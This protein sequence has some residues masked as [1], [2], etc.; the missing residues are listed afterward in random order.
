MSSKTCFS[1]VLCAACALVAACSPEPEAADA[2]SGVGMAHEGHHKM[3]L[4]E[5]EKREK[6]QAARLL[7]ERFGVKACDEAD[8]VGRVRKTEPDGT[9]TIALG[10]SATAACADE[11]QA[12][13]DT[14]G[15]SESEPGVFA[16]EENGRT[17][18]RVFIQRSDD[19]ASAMVEWEAVQK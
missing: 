11:V 12:A 15:F 4:T 14:L 1:I 7:I 6:S 5:T 18:D 10:F 8:M 17:S 9:Q 19:G 13:I 3:E 16:S 2:M